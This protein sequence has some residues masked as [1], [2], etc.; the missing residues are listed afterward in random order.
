MGSGFAARGGVLSALMAQKGLTGSK[1]PLAG[2]WGIY[3]TY[4]RGAFNPKHLT[5]GLGKYFM[6]EN[7]SIKP[8]PCC[9]CIHPLID[10][11]LELVMQQDIRPEDIEK[12][13]A[14]IGHGA[15][16]VIAEPLEL[17]QNP[18]TAIATQFSI[19]WALAST[20]IYRKAE[21]KHF[22]AE[23]LKDKDVHRLARKVITKLDPELTRDG[24]EPAVVRIVTRDKKIYSTRVDHALGSPENPLS[25]EKVVEKFR[26]CADY[27]VTSIS[28]EKLDQVVQM[29]NDLENISNVGQTIQLL[30]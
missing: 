25:M 21:I 15:Y 14:Y 4:L 9:R 22:L 13:T 10:A 3:D 23:A 24:I 26:N 19:P 7:D 18:P 6:V 2:Q 8:Y 12:V 29:I 1:E 27:A 11:T 5:T 28:K 20:I 30:G 17:K 16:N